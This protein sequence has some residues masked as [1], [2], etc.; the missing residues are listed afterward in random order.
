MLRRVFGAFLIALA[1][2][3]IHLSLIDQTVNWA[4]L[5]RLRMS[6]KETEREKERETAIAIDLATMTN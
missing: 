2:S 1:T 3:L 4:T 5:M 6:E